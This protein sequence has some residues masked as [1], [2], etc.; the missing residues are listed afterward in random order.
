MELT[1]FPLRTKDGQVSY[2]NTRSLPRRL[3]LALHG[4]GTTGP[5]KPALFGI[6]GHDD[7][8]RHLVETLSFHY[9]LMQGLVARHPASSLFPWCAM[10]KE[11]SLYRRILEAVVLEEGTTSFGT[12]FG[13][14]TRIFLVPNT[15]R[16]QMSDF[17]YWHLV[18]KWARCLA[19][20]PYVYIRGSSN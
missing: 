13:G 9:F 3:V 15:H 4:F 14:W 18:S 2:L 11:Q 6:Y 5:T 19:D 7:G 20:S 1:F 16:L 8:G 12:V 10:K 17:L